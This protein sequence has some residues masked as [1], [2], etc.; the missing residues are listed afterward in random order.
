MQARTV[1]AGQHEAAV[2]SMLAL[3]QGLASRPAV[4][5]A[6]V[7]TPRRHRRAHRVVAGL[8][9]ARLLGCLRDVRRFQAALIS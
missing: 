3:V 6:L 4:D 7:G 9:G 8:P 5:A 2:G 1:V